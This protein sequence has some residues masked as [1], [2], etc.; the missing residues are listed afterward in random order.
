MYGR[1][2]GK[3]TERLL[4]LYSAPEDIS[5][6]LTF[7]LVVLIQLRIQLNRVC[8]IKSISGYSNRITRTIWLTVCA[9]LDGPIEPMAFDSGG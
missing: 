8:L 9:Q 3:A 6:K 1:R 7:L 2:I 4:T 5:A